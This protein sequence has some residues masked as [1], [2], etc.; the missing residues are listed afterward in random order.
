MYPVSAAFKRAV[1]QSHRATLRAEV[2]QGNV[3]RLNIEPIDGNIDIDSRRAVRRTCSFTVT[4]QSPTTIFEDVFNLY[5]DLQAEFTDYQQLL[6]A[7]P[8]YEQT[9]VIVDRVEVVVDRGIVPRTAGDALTPFGNEVHLWRGVVVDGEVE[10]VPL[11][12][13]VITDVDIVDDGGVKITVRGSDRSIKIARNRW[14][15]SFAIADNTNII[16]ALETMI[17]NRYPEVYINPVDVSASVNAAVFGLDR[18]NDAWRDIQTLATAQ[19]LEVFFDNIGNVTIRAVPDY[20]YATPIE[21]FVEG[22]DAVILTLDRRLTVDK[23]FNGAIVTAEGSNIPTPFRVEVWDEDPASPTYRYGFF[24]QVPQFYSSPA[25]TT[26]ADA[27]QAAVALLNN[28]KGA[29]E[30]VTWSQIV[31]PSLDV[32]DVVQVQNSKTRLNRYMVIDRLTVPFKASENMAAA[33]RTVRTLA[34]VETLEQV[35]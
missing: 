25:I 27:T 6:D 2:W 12:V 19:G 18:Q 32:G 33:A 9:R 15:E 7:F 17:L 31:D 1:R 34:G 16:T 4:S 11:G 13:F 8:S 30:N 5:S 26:V 14:T 3:K 20:E 28:S 22:E 21:A 10:E 23:T 24:G 35:T 29:S